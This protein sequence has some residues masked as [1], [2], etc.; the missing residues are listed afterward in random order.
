MKDHVVR[1]HWW[2]HSLACRKIFVWKVPI[3]LCLMKL[4][5]C[6]ITIVLPF[7]TVTLPLLFRVY[8]LSFSLS[9]SLSF[10]HFIHQLWLDTLCDILFVFET[11]FD[12]RVPRVA[13][14][15]CVYSWIWNVKM[16][17][18]HERFTQFFIIFSFSFLSSAIWLM[19]YF[20]NVEITS[21][22]HREMV[23]EKKHSVLHSKWVPFINQW[24][25]LKEVFQ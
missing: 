1:T 8:F 25:R 18:H 9:R 5:G 6:I 24:K 21:F 22:F 11:L 17:N 19:C 4:N 13:S 12:Y 10:S 16:Q 7:Q 20:I 23:M 14:F 3:A 15:V 2:A